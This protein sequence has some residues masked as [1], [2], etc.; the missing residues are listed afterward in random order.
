MLRAITTEDSVLEGT[1][2]SQILREAVRRLLETP[3]FKRAQ[4]LS[5]LLDYL[6]RQTL[7][8]DTESMKEGSI[9]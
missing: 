9:G 6:A 2:N 3:T 1:P 5:E 7:A 4:R 8:G